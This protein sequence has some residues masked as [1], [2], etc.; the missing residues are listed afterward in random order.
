MSDP[1]KSIH[2]TY[3]AKTPIIMRKVGDAILLFGT[4]M[5]ASLAGA[6]VG[7]GW[8]I[9]SAILTASGKMI[10]NFFKDEE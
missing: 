1:I 3:Y 10:T 5:T 8:I 7:K 2:D 4:T 9:A 6:E